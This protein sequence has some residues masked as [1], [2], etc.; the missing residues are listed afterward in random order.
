[1]FEL[2]KVLLNSYNSMGIDAFSKKEDA[3]FSFKRWGC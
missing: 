1:M 3:L 2:C